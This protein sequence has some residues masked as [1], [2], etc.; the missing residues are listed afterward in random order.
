M[1]VRRTQISSTATSSLWRDQNLL[2]KLYWEDELSLS[3]IA[4]QLVCHKST[5]K[6]WADRHG[7]ELRPANDQK[8]HPSIWTNDKGYTYAESTADGY[9][10]LVAIHELLAIHA[11]ADPHEVFSSDTEIHHRM[12]MPGNFDAPKLDIPGDVTVVDSH[13]HQVGHREDALERPPLEVILG[14][15]E[16]G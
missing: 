8:R 11:G 10:G 1:S 2:D 5:V 12:A 7:I 4:S 9:R 15:H 6:R 16:E 3:E 14:A 13:A